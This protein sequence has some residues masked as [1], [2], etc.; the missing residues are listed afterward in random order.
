MGA[1]LAPIKP[2]IREFVYTSVLRPAAPYTHISEKEYTK[3]KS[4][5]DGPPPSAARALLVLDAT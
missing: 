1:A 4:R 5:M 2:T 3:I